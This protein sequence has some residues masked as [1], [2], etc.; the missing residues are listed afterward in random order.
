MQKTVQWD[1]NTIRSKYSRNAH[2][3]NMKRL[4]IKTDAQNKML[5]TRKRKLLILITK[6]HSY[7]YAIIRASSLTDPSVFLQ[8]LSG[9]YGQRKIL[10]LIRIYLSEYK[11]LGDCGASQPCPTRSLEL[12]KQGVVLVIQYTL[13]VLYCT[14]TVIALQ[15][16]LL[17]TT[18]LTILAKKNYHIQIQAMSM[19]ESSLSQ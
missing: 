14:S 19:S 15:L 17:S 1:Q 11:L 5:R 7:N 10:S 6:K 16:Q 2:N 13:L 3:Q 18:L 4:Y 8:I 12:E 9:F